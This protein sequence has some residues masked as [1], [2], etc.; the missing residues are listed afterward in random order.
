MISSNDTQ[1]GRTYS[2]CRMPPRGCDRIA[3]QFSAAHEQHC[4]CN[5]FASIRSRSVTAPLQLFL[6]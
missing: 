6:S 3:S 2:R 1:Q 4:N 5:H